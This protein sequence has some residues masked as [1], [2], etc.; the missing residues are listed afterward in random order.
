MSPLVICD[1]L[2]KYVGILRQLCKERK[3]GLL[4]PTI[5][6]V[7]P[8]A[9]GTLLW[10][11]GKRDETCITPTMHPTLLVQ[12]AY[13]SLPVHYAELVPHLPTHDF[14]TI[15]TFFARIPQKACV[16]CS[17]FYYIFA[18]KGPPFGWSPRVTPLG[19]VPGAH[20]CGVSAADCDKERV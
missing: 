11:H 19:M 12:T 20:A 13:A 4:L 6:D 18:L 3:A 5:H 10:V 15:P 1:K 9:T 2:A 16:L 7:S 14:R 8:A 17:T